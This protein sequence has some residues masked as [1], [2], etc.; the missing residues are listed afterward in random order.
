MLNKKFLPS[1]DGQCLFVPSVILVKIDKIEILLKI[2]IGINIKQQIINTY[3][4][5]ILEKKIFYAN[6]YS[7]IIKIIE[8]II[9]FYFFWSN[10]LR[11]NLKIY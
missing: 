10:S 7:N 6:K 4:L 2:K 3:L 5:G 11:K 8:K 1:Y 9:N